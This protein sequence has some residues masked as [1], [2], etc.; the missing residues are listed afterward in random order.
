M[1][2]AAKY[3]KSLPQKRMAS[4][5][6][7]CNEKGQVLLV[8]PTYKKRWGVPGGSVE[9]NESPKQAAIR[10]VKEEL[11]LKITQLPLVG[12]DYTIPSGPKDEAIM[13]VFYG[14]ILNSKDIRKIKLPAEEL[15]DYVFVPVSKAKVMVRDEQIHI[16]LPERLEESLKKI[17]TD[18]LYLEDGKPR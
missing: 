4:E 15:S 1:L 3:Y 5:V 7:F 13:F 9:K 14:G 16:S 10:E 18:A 17:T 6:I 2:P 11:G 12:V 8:K